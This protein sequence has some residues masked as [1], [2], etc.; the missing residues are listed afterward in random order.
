MKYL[1][2]HTR[3][4]SSNMLKL[5]TGFVA[6]EKTDTLRKEINVLFFPL[7]NSV[8]LADGNIKNGN[9]IVFLLEI[10]CN[11]VGTFFILAR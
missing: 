5:H 10:F 9:L 2:E 7:Q 3:N 4:L 8:A 11:F 6:L 1:N